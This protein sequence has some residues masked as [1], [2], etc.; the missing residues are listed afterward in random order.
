MIP[1]KYFKENVI[2]EVSIQ[3]NEFIENTAIEGGAIKWMQSLPSFL[4][5]NTYQSNTAIYGPN[6]AA[7]PLKF[8]LNLY[9]KQGNFICNDNLNIINLTNI[10]SGG[11][12]PYVL[13]FVLLDYY[14]QI[15]S[16]ISEEY[17]LQS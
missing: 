14:N 7:F 9:D 12:F 4:S 5:D 2:N 13:N 1:I 6:I 8:S 10:Q 17:N 11:L 16:S 15:V 3:K